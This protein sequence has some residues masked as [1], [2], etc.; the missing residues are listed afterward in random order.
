MALHVAQQEQFINEALAD[1]KP[2][3]D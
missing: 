3:N 1:D 2:G